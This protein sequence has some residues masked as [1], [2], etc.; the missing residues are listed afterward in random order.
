MSISY[1]RQSDWR[2]PELELAWD[3][4]LD[5][6]G[7]GDWI[8]QPSTAAQNRGGLANL[9][10]LRTAVIL[11]LFTD[12]RVPAR[13]PL[14]HFADP[15]DR[16]GW[17]GNGVDV[18]ADLGEAELGSLLW[19]LERAPLTEATLQ[20]AQAL[21]QEALAPLITQG[22]AA[23]IDIRAERNAQSNRL[24]LLIQIYAQNGTTLF[25]QK[26]ELVWRQVMS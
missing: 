26:F 15:R 24:D 2:L 4:V 25:N 16:R 23:K 11:A 13:H 19:L 10:A 18:R 8:L 17:W 9:A 5:A 7:Q 22:L 3:T 20:W 1:L 12:A 21:A 14:A 6:G